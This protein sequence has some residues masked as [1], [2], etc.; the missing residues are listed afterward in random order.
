MTVPSESAVTVKKYVVPSPVGAD[1][2]AAADPDTVIS[3]A[4]S[5]PVTASSKVAVYDIM[6][7]PVVRPSAVSAVMVTAGM[8]ASTIMACVSDDMLPLPASVVATFSGMITMTVPSRMVATS[9]V[10]YVALNFIKFDGAGESPDA[11][12]VITI[13]DSVKSFTSMSNVTM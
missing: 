4:V 6:L 12:P 7:V 2:V 10:Y 3:D 8:W 13:S 5:K 9:K 1:A 11:V